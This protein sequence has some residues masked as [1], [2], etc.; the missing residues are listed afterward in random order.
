MKILFLLINLK[1]YNPQLPPERALP[2]DPGPSDRGAGA[3]EDPGGRGGRHA[4]PPRT[5]VHAKEAAQNQVQILSFLR[6]F[7]S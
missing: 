4:L 5:H 1:L 3:K 2:P 6:Y 7:L